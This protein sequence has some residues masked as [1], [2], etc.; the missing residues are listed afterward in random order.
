MNKWILLTA[1]FAFSE[2]VLAYKT[3]THGQL[4]RMSAT[5]SSLYQ[6]IQHFGF[7]PSQTFPN[8]FGEPMTPIN[9]MSFGAHFE[10]GCGEIGTATQCGQDSSY[11][12]GENAVNHFYDPQRGGEGLPM[13]TKNVASSADWSLEDRGQVGAQAF[14]AGI[15]STNPQQYSYE[16]GIGYF[17]QALTASSQG[18][19]NSAAG[20]MFQTFGHIAH[21]LHDMA[22]PQHVRED[23]HCDTLACMVIGQ[24]QPSVLESVAAKSDVIDQCIRPWVNNRHTIYGDAP[25]FASHSPRYYWNT[26]DG[27]GMAEFTAENFVSV[28]TN[29]EGDINHPQ[30]THY[31]PNPDFSDPKWRTEVV[32]IK[33]MLSTTCLKAANPQYNELEGKLTFITHDITDPYNNKDYNDLKISTYSIFTDD[34]QQKNEVFPDSEIFT[35]IF[36]MNPFNYEDI[37][38]VTLPR[39]VEWIDGLINYFFRGKLGVTVNDKTITV[40]NTS[41]M[42]MDGH[43]SIYYD[44]TNHNRSPLTTTSASLANNQTKSI[45]ITDIP[46]PS[47][48]F[49]GKY[50]AVFD[51]DIGVYKG[52]AAQTFNGPYVQPTPCGSSL[53]FSGGTGEESRLAYELGDISGRVY[54]EFEAYQIPDSFTV[55]TSS[56][57]TLQS[58]DLVQGYNVYQFDHNPSTDGS[59]VDVTVTGNDDLGTAWTFAMGCPGG[60]PNTLSRVNVQ[61]SSSGNSICHAD[62]YVDGSKVGL[63]DGFSG[64]ISAMLTPGTNHYY[65]YRN[66]SN[67]VSDSCNFTYND[68]WTVTYRDSAGVHTLGSPIYSRG[69]YFT[70][71]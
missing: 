14:C 61:F 40:Q 43:L 32:D 25:V 2:Q 56:G 52:L 67:G 41:G 65:Q 48:G 6:S 46:T 23:K 42:N 28:G 27:K 29:F 53:S 7:S 15:V 49:N 20:R 36:S 35:P 30:S 38:R 24:Y 71:Q 44:D 39:T 62:L 58:A 5:G 63:L 66:Y 31:E 34:L 37:Y 70:V 57:K 18:T 60:S 11:P 50:I 19:R 12:N 55:K 13:C 59:T 16:D 45:T 21:H 51:G 8:A 69:N 9:L 1:L 68:T 33:D 54:I 22:Q 47:A 10:D 3:E 17:R 26:T 4:A 64:G